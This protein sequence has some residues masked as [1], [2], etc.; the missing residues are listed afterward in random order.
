MEKRMKCSSKEHQ[1]IEAQFYCQKCNIY[2]C[3]KCEKFHSNI[4][5]EHIKFPLDKDN[6]DIFT[7]FC[8]EKDHQ[9]KLLFFCKSH[10]KLCC[11]SCLCKIKKKGYGQHKDCDVCEIEDIKEDKKNKY[12]EN[13]KYLENLSLNIQESIN[14]LKLIYEK[15]EENKE[16]FI[17]Q[18]QKIFTKLRSALNEREDELML[19]INEKYKKIYL[20][21]E[22]IK[23]NEKLPNQ[24]KTIL[25]NSKNN[26]NKWN[27]ND[28]LNV[29]INECLEIEEKID[30]IKKINS[31]LKPNNI[32]LNLAFI[33][34]KFKINEFIQTIKNFGGIIQSK[35]C[36]I[37]SSSD[38]LRKCLCKKIFCL[39]CLNNKKNIECLTSCYLFNNNLNN[40]DKIY[41]ISKFP[42]PKNFEIKLYFPNVDSIRS[43]ITFD[44]SIINC[45]SDSNSPKYDIYYI[46][47][48]LDNFYTLKDQWNNHF[49]K[50]NRKL[51]S[52][53]FMTIN[54]KDGKMIYKI[55]DAQLDVVVNVS[56][57]DNNEMHLLV[58]DRKL[59]SKC[60][61]V[62]IT[63]L[64]D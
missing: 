1:E 49:N 3:N 56:K 57:H 31:A 16:Q 58:H 6:S 8:K 64:L 11:S 48:K 36:S 63:E 4:F 42:L 17:S 40:I 59:K 29:D 44:K 53:D 34:D 35:C 52:G 45:N 20:G 46:Y 22:I 28:K 39:K 30:R 43:G 21:D 7:G 2:M 41:N 32:G 50:F 14:N 54:M 24:I 10:N 12:E 23:E 18:V 47:E 60:N 13:I 25:E 26:E 62:Y 37:C 15:I 19:I 27:N 38:D 33:P 9:N 55:N 61:I 51:Q 5:L